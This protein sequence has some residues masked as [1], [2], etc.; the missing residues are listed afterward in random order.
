MMISPATSRRAS[1][2]ALDHRAG[3][4]MVQALA[5]MLLYRLLSF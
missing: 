5:A 1:D 4:S 3:A 2:R